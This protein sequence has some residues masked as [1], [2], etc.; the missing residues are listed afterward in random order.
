MLIRPGITTTWSGTIKSRAFSFPKWSQL[1]RG[2]CDITC[3]NS[4][5]CHWFQRPDESVVVW[6]LSGIGL[7]I[8]N[9]PRE[10]RYWGQ[11]VLKPRTVICPV[12][13]FLAP[14]LLIIAR[15]FSP[16]VRLVSGC[17]SVM[18][19]DLLLSSNLCHCICG[20]DCTNNCSCGDERC[21]SGMIEQMVSEKMTWTVLDWDRCHTCRPWSRSVQTVYEGI[22]PI[23]GTAMAFGKSG[24]DRN[25][26]R[27]TRLLSS[28]VIPDG[29]S[30][31][32]VVQSLRY[33]ISMLISTC[34]ISEAGEQSRTADRVWIAILLWCDV[35]FRACPW[36]S[37][38]KQGLTSVLLHEVVVPFL[39]LKTL[40]R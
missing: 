11:S 1:V 14:H 26:E 33:G 2:H 12:I 21:D 15:F 16:L 18:A 34:C 4:C 13:A 23:N 40:F 32:D 9:V 8:F 35:V 24:I 30:V 37:W 20:W 6:D 29:K 19:I 39:R 7:T 3:V 10:Y 27:F 25:T 17:N 22:T 5:D 31:N 36:P 38:L 28:F